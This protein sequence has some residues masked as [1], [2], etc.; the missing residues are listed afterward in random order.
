MGS[1]SASASQLMHQSQGPHT[2]VTLNPCD[3]S[4]SFSFSLLL[5][6]PPLSENLLLS[7][8]CRKKIMSFS[9][10]YL[11]LLYSKYFSTLLKQF[12]WPDLAVHV[13]KGRKSYLY[14]SVLGGTNFIINLPD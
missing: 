7:S 13:Y 9:L 10:C 8:L 6:S 2:V 12:S 3:T 1:N 11:G 14:N 4:Q 5:A